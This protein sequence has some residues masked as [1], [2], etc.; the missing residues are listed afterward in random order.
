MCRE[1]LKFWSGSFVGSWSKKEPQELIQESLEAHGE[2]H[3][4]GPHRRSNPGPSYHAT[5]S[6]GRSSEHLDVLQNICCTALVQSFKPIRF[7][8]S[9]NKSEEDNGELSSQRADVFL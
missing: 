2:L 4:A 9:F 1:D 3:T 7:H 8:L 5:T 6:S